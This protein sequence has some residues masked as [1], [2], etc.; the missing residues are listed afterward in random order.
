LYDKYIGESEKHLE[1]ALTVAEVLAPCVLMIDEIEKGFAYSGTAESDAGLCRRIFGRLLTWMRERKAP[2]FIVA[3]CNDVLQLPPE[4]VRKG[5]FDEIFFIDLP[6]PEERKSIFEIHLRKGQRDPVN[7]DL[8]ALVAP[9]EGFSGAE[10]DQAIISAL[11]TA[12]AKHKDL[13]TEHILN[14]PRSTH[15]L[16]AVR[17]EA[18]DELRQWAHGRPVM[19]S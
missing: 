3:T 14:E 15:P 8:P 9:A 4:L 12:F 5:R 6:G 10:I 2:V 11:Y 7:F 19:A 13:T 18:I 16:S 1:R 17:Q